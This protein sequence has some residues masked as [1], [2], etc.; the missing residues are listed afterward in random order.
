MAL[1]Q[2]EQAAALLAAMVSVVERAA[3]EL[4]EQTGQLPVALVASMGV[5]R[6]WPGFAAG[7]HTACLAV[8][9]QCELSGAYL[10]CVAPHLSRQQT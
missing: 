7:L 9:A 2:T 5:E 10:V 3:E 6:V 4:L 8:E 1:V